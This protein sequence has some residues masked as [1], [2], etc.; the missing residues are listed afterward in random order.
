[1]HYSVQNNT[2]QITDI[3]TLQFTPICKLATLY[4]STTR[5]ALWAMEQ[6]LSHHTTRFWFR[7]DFK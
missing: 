4:T 7:P 6:P 5:R 2:N 3:N 1:M